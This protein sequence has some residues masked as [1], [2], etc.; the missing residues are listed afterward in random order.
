M[1]KTKYCSG[2]NTTKEITQFHIDNSEKDG[3]RFQCKVCRNAKQR[4]YA[5]N[6]K[7]VIKIRNAAK[8]EQRKVY[9]QSD[10]GIESSR[11]SH[12]KRK[13]DI[14]LEEYNK[15]LKQQNN[16]CKICNSE[17]TCQRNNFL[18][19]DHEHSTGRIRGL[20][21]NNCN[22]AL[23]LFQDSMDVLHNAIMYLQNN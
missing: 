21:C 16:K 10:K 11:R 13:Y 3:H 20:L 5:K 22:R 23:G 6:N 17:E 1:E 12:L 8:A 18:S 7:D 9:Y 15:L 19:V 14:T 2:C 4:E